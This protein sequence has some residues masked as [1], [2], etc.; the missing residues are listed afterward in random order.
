MKGS[1]EGRITWGSIFGT[2]FFSGNAR[3]FVEGSDAILGPIHLCIG[4]IV[5][6]PDCHAAGRCGARHG[7]TTFDTLGL[8]SQSRGTGISGGGNP[9]FPPDMGDFMDAE[10][11]RLIALSLDGAE[12]GSHMGTEFASA[13][14]SRDPRHAASGV[15]QSDVVARIQQALV[16]EAPEVFLAIP[17]GWGRKGFTH[18]RLAATSEAEQILKGLQLAWNLRIEKNGKSR[19]SRPRRKK[20]RR[21]AIASV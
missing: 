10:D 12:E 14:A 11:F 1:V 2:C 16:A 21:K 4:W 19:S 13:A 3:S 20:G 8:R 18:I 15:R 9:S 6:G 7:Q 17:G 5:V